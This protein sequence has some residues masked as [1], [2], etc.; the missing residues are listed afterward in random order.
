[1]LRPYFW[2]CS[3]L[4]K[5][6]QNGLADVAHPRIKICGITRAVDARHCEASGVDAIGFV[7]VEKSKRRVSVDRAAEIARA[8]GPFVT[9]T[10]LFLNASTPSVMQAL[11]AIP[12]LLLQFHG[13]ET[14]AWC[15]AFDRPYIKAIGLGSG[16]P[17]WQE[18]AHYRNASA[19]LFDSNTAGELGGTGHSFD[20]TLLHGYLGRPL[21]LA[22]GLSIDN[23]AQAIEQ[24]SPYAVD[25]SSSV[26]S[27]PGI[28]DPALITRFVATTRASTA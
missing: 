15:D 3:R 17:Q 7:F 28:K 9:R 12:D 13:Q 11:T 21:I 2:Y 10:G 26:E 20:W 25:V 19:F 4:R 1:V 14:A 18:L 5:H 23:L 8:L 27:A 6:P 16:T 22:G 24:V